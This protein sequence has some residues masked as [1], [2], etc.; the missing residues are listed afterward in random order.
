M[1]KL[2]DRRT[3]ISGGRRFLKFRRR[4]LKL[5]KLRC[6][7]DGWLSDTATFTTNFFVASTKVVNP[8]QNMRLPS[9]GKSG[10]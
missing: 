8:P 10:D 4:L 9:T 3:M 1:K 5:L 2:C 6:P 7:T